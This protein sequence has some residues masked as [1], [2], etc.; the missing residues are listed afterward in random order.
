[1]RAIVDEPD[2]GL[3]ASLL[4]ELEPIATSLLVVIVAPL[5]KLT[6]LGI[7]LLLIVRERKV[8]EP[9]IVNDSFH[10]FIFTTTSLKVLLRVSNDESVESV[11]IITS[12]EPGIMVRLL[13]ANEILPIIQLSKLLGNY[14][15]ITT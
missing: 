6:V 5:S 14:N 8:G 10:Q 2:E 7:F 1:M 3:I 15:T 4:D 13:P 11:S 12:E 9:V